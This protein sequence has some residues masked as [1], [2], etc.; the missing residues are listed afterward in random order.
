MLF[1][2]I[3]IVRNVLELHNDLGRFERQSF[4][5]TNIEWHTRPAE[6]IH[7]NTRSEISFC[8]RLRIHGILFTVGRQRLAFGRTTCILTTN[9]IRTYI[10]TIFE[11][12]KGTKHLHLLIANILRM[13]SARRLHRHHH[14]H[15]QHVILSHITKCAR[16]VIVPTAL[17]NANRLT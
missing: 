14:Q 5:R 1:S 4:T 13:Q 8:R 2:E 11:H 3:D 10:I 7:V 6:I 15:L 17:F 9:Y 16:M 12:T